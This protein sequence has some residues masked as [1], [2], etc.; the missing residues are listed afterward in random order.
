MTAPA[1]KQNHRRE[2]AEQADALLK[3]ARLD[4]MTGA[5]KDRAYH[6]NK[7]AENKRRGPH[8]RAKRK[9]L[10]TLGPASS[11]RTVTTGDEKESGAKLLTRP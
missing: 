4:P 7:R 6:R 8:Q 2:L 5:K 1:S 11:V 9:Q 3:A 10:G